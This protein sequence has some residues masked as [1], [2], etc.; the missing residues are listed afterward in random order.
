[1]GW[2]RATYLREGMGGLPPSWLLYCTFFL[3]S[4]DDWTLGGMSET[5][6]KSTALETR[7]NI[8]FF[9][10]LKEYNRI[11]SYDGWLTLSVEVA[12]LFDLSAL[13]FT[14]SP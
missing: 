2:S 5:C 14:S 1:M 8:S 12:T 6:S 10:T 11:L 3:I 13:V 4:R 9:L 7:L